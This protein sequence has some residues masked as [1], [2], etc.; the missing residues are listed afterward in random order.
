[1][2][3]GKANYN[4]ALESVERRHP[5]KGR[6]LSHVI[7]R[8]KAAFVGAAESED[9]GGGLCTPK[10]SRHGLMKVRTLLLLVS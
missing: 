10:K 8:S 4:V 7:K 5:A 9:T 3:A 1:M 2:R 6:R